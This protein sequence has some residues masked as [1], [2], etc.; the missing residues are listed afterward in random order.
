MHTHIYFLLDRTGSMEPM[1]TDVIG[2]FNEFIREQQAD[3]SDARMTLV[4]FDSQAPFE[5]LVDGAAIAKIRPLTSA[6]FQPRGSTPLLDATAKLILHAAARVTRREAAGKK[7]E[8]VLVVTFTDGA[9]N[10]SEHFTTADVMEMVEG[11]K[12]AGWT[13]AFLGAGLDAYEGGR[14]FG[15]ADGSARQFAPDGAGAQTAFAMLSE[16]TRSYRSR[17]RQ[18]EAPDVDRFFESEG[19][20][21]DAEPAPSA[22]RAR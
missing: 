8:Q 3:G 11:K 13:F 9:E 2:G 21:D 15:Y 14:G 1:A 19:V 7:P 4:Q 16:S 5:V 12:A 10:A 6:T 22:R 18:G 20:S 17:G